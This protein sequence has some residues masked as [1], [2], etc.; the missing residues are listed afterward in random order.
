MRT[1]TDSDGAVNRK[2]GFESRLYRPKRKSLKNT[3]IRK[4]CVKLIR[5]LV[6][7]ERRPSEVD[8]Y[9]NPITHPTSESLVA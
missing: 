5:M 3:K 6:T 7:N 2:C 9:T 4:M 1:V 8:A